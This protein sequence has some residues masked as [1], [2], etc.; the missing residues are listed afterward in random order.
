[1]KDSIST[2]ITYPHPVE[3]VWAAL[4]DPA[5]LSQWLMPTDFRPEVGHRFRFTTKPYPGFDG[6]VNCRVLTVEE[7]KLLEYSWSG[8]GLEDTRVT[9]RLEA[10]GPETVLHFTHAGFNGFFNQLVTRRILASGWRKKILRE[11]LLN[12]LGDG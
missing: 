5:A 11:Q 6:T 3:R 9:F 1:M 7:P 12:Y 8:G 10:R 2:T 4:T